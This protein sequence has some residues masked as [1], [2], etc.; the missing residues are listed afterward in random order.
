MGFFGFEFPALFFFENRIGG[1]RAPFIMFVLNSSQKST[2]S[3]CLRVPTVL[4][5]ATRDK[6]IMVTRGKKRNT[7][8]LVA[9]DDRLVIHIQIECWPWPSRA[10][11]AQ[12][13]A[14]LGRLGALEE[15][16]EGKEGEERER[17]GKREREGKRERRE[18]GE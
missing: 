5:N 1:N 6:T 4:S 14:G 12:V 8:E 13:R 3:A 7:D 17:R 15:R 11:K 10:F 2:H 16:E 9:A 18:R